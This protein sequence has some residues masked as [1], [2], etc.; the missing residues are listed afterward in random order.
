MQT[1][2]STHP[3]KPPS[4]L[5]PRV[6]AVLALVIVGVIAGALIAG[7]LG[8]SSSESTSPTPTTHASAGPKHPYYVVKAGDSFLGIAHAE[9]VSEARLK[10]LNP[11]LDPLNLQPLNCVDL[12][13]HGC[14]K[15]AAQN[16][17]C[18][19]PPPRRPSSRAC[20]PP[21]ASPRPSDR[22]RRGSTPAP[23]P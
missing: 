10:Q 8:G 3:E 16:G 4:K 17:G 21:R 18:A 14:R 9:G 20:S 12:V 22:R 7:G 11:N 15:L 19:A 13:P 2:S 23:G 5:A 6:F 1:V